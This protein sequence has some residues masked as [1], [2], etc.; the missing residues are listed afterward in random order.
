MNDER[1][2]KRRNFNL[3]PDSHSDRYLRSTPRVMEIR[4]AIVDLV[5][6][7]A[8]TGLNQYYCQVSFRVRLADM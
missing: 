5:W 7:Q 2:E 3:I 1:D 8:W 6:F 4:P